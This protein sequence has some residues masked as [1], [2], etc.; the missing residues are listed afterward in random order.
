MTMPPFTED[1]EKARPFFAALRALR[2]RCGAEWGYPLDGLSM[3][4]TR[5][6]EVAIEEGSTCI[7]VGT[8]LFGRRTAIKPAG[9]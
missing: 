8:A 5:D 9:A 3:G 1:L 7:R 2:D 6:F 4:M